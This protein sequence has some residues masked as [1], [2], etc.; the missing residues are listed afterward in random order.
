[1]R[2]AEG[3]FHFKLCYPDLAPVLA[4]E[5]RHFP[6]NEWIQ[7]SNPLTQQKITGFAGISLTWN[8]N[9]IGGPFQGLGLNLPDRGFN[10]IDATPD[11]RGWWYSIGSLKYHSGPDS[12]PGPWPYVVKRVVLYVFYT[13]RG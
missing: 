6:C 11:D 10:L 2:N 13:P 7:S 8:T 9:G 5:K 3:F 12:V 4:F 1:M